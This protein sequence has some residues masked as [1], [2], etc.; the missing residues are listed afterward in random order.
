M[1]APVPPLHL[2]HRASKVQVDHLVPKIKQDFSP[3][4]ISSGW[5][6]IN[7]PAMGW[8]QSRGSVFFQITR[9]A[10]L[11]QRSGSSGCGL[12]LRKSRCVQQRFGDTKGATMATCHQTHRSVGVP[13]QTRLKKWR[14]EPGTK[15]GTR[16]SMVVSRAMSAKGL[17]NVRSGNGPSGSSTVVI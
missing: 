17:D 14:I 5:V 15:A 2:L 11:R 3:R 1:T 7:C 6:P 16:G 9:A 4:A 10:L 12:C 13:R 8:S